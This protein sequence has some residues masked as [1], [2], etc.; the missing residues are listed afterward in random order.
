MTD[1]FQLTES[2]GQNSRI[3]KP[4]EVPYTN[5]IKG[6]I[7][8]QKQ[9]F[10]ELPIRSILEINLQPDSKLTRKT[11]GKG[12]MKMKGTAIKVYLAT[13]IFKFK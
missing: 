6:K 1:H 8:A 11:A 5:Q 13:C 2:K 9:K 10:R 7:F 4:S 12:K 3:L